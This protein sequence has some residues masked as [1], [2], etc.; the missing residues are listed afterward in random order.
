M[1]AAIEE[2]L[3]DPGC[4]TLGAA[5]LARL[6]REGEPDWSVGFVSVAAG[7]MQASFL[8]QC[9][10]RGTA[11]MIGGGAEIYARFERTGVERSH[12]RRRPDCD[13]C[14]DENRQRRFREL[15]DHSVPPDG[16]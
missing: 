14:G 5:E 9:A 4:G 16:S 3:K 12:S 11:A 7:V 13:I 8:L 15:W 2:H 6:G 1:I 10:M